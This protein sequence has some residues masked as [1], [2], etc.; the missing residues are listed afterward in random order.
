MDLLSSLGRLEQLEKLMAEGDEWHFVNPQD[1]DM[2]REAKNSYYLMKAHPEIAYR[3]G[4]YALKAVGGYL[5][6]TNSALQSLVEI[7][8]PTNGFSVAGL[9]DIAKKYG[10]KMT[11]VRRAPGQDLITP[12]VV[13]WRQNH[14]AAILEHNDDLYLVSDPTFGQEKWLSAEVINEEASG[15]FLVPTE[16][17]TDGW[18]QLARNEQMNIHGMGLP[19]NIKNGK[20]KGCVPNCPICPVCKGMPIWWVTEPY[21]DLWL[22]DEPISYLT[23][24]GESFGF[25]LSY[26]QR[27]TRPNPLYGASGANGVANTGWNH[28]WFSS[29]YVQSFAPCSPSPCVVASLGHATATVYL[30]D[31]GEVNFAAGQSYDQETR[32]LLQEMVPQVNLASGDDDGRHGLRLVHADGSQDIYGHSLIGSGPAGDYAPAYFLRTRHIDALGNTTWYNYGA[33]NSMVV[34]LSVTDPDGRT[35][36]LKYNSS[37]LLSEVDNPYGLNATFKYDANRNLTNMVDAAGMSSSI[38]YDTNGYPTTL[39]TPYGTNQFNL[40]DNGLTYLGGAVGNAG[41]DNNGLIDRSALVVDPTGATDLYMYRFDSQQVL[42][43]TNF[44]NV[45]TN[46]PLGTLDAG[47]GP[48]TNGAAYFRNSFHWGPRQF[49]NLS[50]QNMTNFL[51]SDYLMGHMRHWLQ[52]TNSLYVT[53]LVSVEREPSPSLTGSVEGLKTFYDYQGKTA[54]YIEGTNALASVKAWCLPGGETHYEYMLYDAY[55]NLTND[56]TTYTRSDGSIGTRTNQFIYAKNTYTN[57]FGLWSGSSLYNGGQTN[58]TLANLLTE[59]IGPDGNIIW[60]YGG[61]DAVTWTNIFITSNGSGPTATNAT[62]LTSYRVLPDYTT[63]GVGQMESFTYTGGSAFNNL[64]NDGVNISGYTG[65]GKISGHTSVAGLT[66][67]NF[68]NAGGFLAQTIDLQIQRTNSFG[69]TTNG[70]VGTFTNELG[71]NVSALWDPLLRLTSVQFPDGSYVSN[72]Y[73]RLDVGGTRDRLGN[74][75]TY[76]HDGARH[77]VA[78]TNANNAVTIFDWCG[79]GALTAI[80]DPFLHQT[81]F[82][83]DNQGNVTNI[84]Y[85]DGSALNYQYDLA[86]RPISASDGASRAFQYTYNNQGLVEVVSNAYGLVRSVFYDIRDRAATVTNVNAVV[87]ANAFD[88]LDRILTRSWANG[89]AEGFGYSAQGL[90][91]YTNQLNQVTLYGRDAATRLTAQTNANNETTLM[92]YDPAGDVRT[93]VDGKNQTTTWTYDLYGNVSNKVDAA[94]NLLLVYHYDANNRLTSRWSAAK[95]STSY[96][97]D[98]FG[99]LTNIVYP[100]SSNIA[101]A[102]DALN[103]LTRM[104]DGVGTNTFG[105]SEI[106]QLTNETGPWAGD[107]VS[108]GY[109]QQLRTSLSLSEP[110]GTWSQSYGYDNA[111]RLNSVG[112]GAGSFGYSFYTAGSRL[113][114]SITLPNG[115][116]ITN[117]YDGLAR[118]LS[119][120]LVSS[121]AAVLDSESYGYDLGNERTQAVFTAGNSVNYGYDAIG[122]LKSAIGKEAGGTVNRLQ[123]QFGYGY[124]AADNLNYRTNNGLVQTFNVN[125]LNELGTVT[126]SGTV[127]V[128]GTTTV[129]ATSVTVNG[130]TANHYADATFALG[131]FGLTNGVNGYTAVGWDAVGN[132][133]TNSVVVNLPGTNSYTYDLNGNLLSDGSRGFDYDDEN[134]LVRV[135]MTNSFK[136]EYV[137]DGL[138][139]LRV[140]REYGWTGAWVETNE[141]RYIYDGNEILQQ[142]DGNN[143]PTLTFTRGLDM[144]GSLQG[145]NGIGG[146]LAMTEGTGTNSYYHSDGNG[147]VVYLLGTNQLLAARYEYDAFGSPQAIS[148]P[149]AYINPNWYASQLYDPATGLSHYL[150]RAY[151]PSLQRWLTR[152]PLGEFGGINLYGFVRNGP[153]NW[154]DR[155]GLFVAAN[156][157]D[158]YASGAGA[159]PANQQMMAAMGVGA[160]ASAATAAAVAALAPEGAAAWAVGAASG[161][162]GGYV[163]NGVQNEINGQ[164]FNQ[165]A[166]QATGVGAALGAAAGAVGDA[167]NAPKPKSCPAKVPPTPPV[168]PKTPPK[169]V[170]APGSKPSNSNIAVYNSADNTL[171]VG[172]STPSMHPL[173]LDS[174]GIDWESNP[175]QFVGGFASFQDGALTGFE[176]N[177]GH[178]PGTPSTISQAQNAVSQLIGTH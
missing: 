40:T 154:V 158:Y 111:R 45:P 29:I 59:V 23:S 148:G 167:I 123:E 83:Y 134:E 58:Y 125:P 99:N 64:S 85:P 87:V 97:Y 117:Q 105:Y 172:P 116:S 66:T 150:Y 146:L 68:Y 24:R 136:K 49:A 145:A 96:G 120:K 100:V 62:L 35:N 144:S 44:L 122:Q 163:G 27:D 67:T 95:G 149:K 36:F 76:G 86:A 142:R 130:L 151:V 131:G 92:T 153:E 31:G 178:F 80:I 16:Q 169:M 107:T 51:A 42:A 113:P 9:V 177:S 137:Y 106:G 101:L 84:S 41:G 174:M 20:D 8:S 112:S 19:G 17:L 119:T 57:A 91:Y 2:Y 152:D 170:F 104:V 81:S 164:P 78:V 124:D 171:I 133:G 63:N 43:T 21:I 141:I 50:T 127:T 69:Y 14:Y 7:P 159:D 18:K 175:S 52:D 38:T 15:E 53:E 166:G 168:N 118:L 4:T 55:G 46:T 3:C 88:P 65:Y 61:F 82:N 93:L 132:A 102:Y 37:T 12:S 89:A 28:S 115:A 77:L 5:E 165:N 56:I 48:S 34:L 73:D 110:S 1:R 114:V 90:A 75:T 94:N 103:R 22:R 161:A 74:W 98:G 138:R 25:Q 79:C 39:I 140:R 109:G 129:P 6:P 11:A 30:P 54:T 26:K 126:N 10:L 32:L 71:L 156:S 108:V 155:Y 147:N 160:I 70:V 143:V 72:R 13:H 176:V 139:R 121:A 60:S 157:L 173:V 162:A 33:T 128:S 47:V 135:T